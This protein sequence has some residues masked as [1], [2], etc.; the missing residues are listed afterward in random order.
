MSK[1]GAPIIF[2]LS[3]LAFGFPVL[4]Y[5]IG[6]I[7][8]VSSA[9]VFLQTS[10]IFFFLI[11]ISILIGAVVSF[12]TDFQS[13]VKSLIGLAVI[14]ILWGIAYAMSNNEVNKVYEKMN[15]GAGLSQLTESTLILSYLLFVIV[16]IAIVVTEVKN[17]LE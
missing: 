7:S 14:L 10:Y 16:A 15:V 13:S 17:S 12:I 3:I 5:L 6:S 1:I 4:L 11:V 2:I 8:A 9:E